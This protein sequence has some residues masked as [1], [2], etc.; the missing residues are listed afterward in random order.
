L[1]DAS[2]PNP[3]LIVQLETQLD[4]R[5]VRTA[6]TVAGWILVVVILVMTWGPI[7]DRPQLGF[8]QIERFAAYFVLASIFAVAYPR[9]PRRVG[10]GLVVGAIVLEIGQGFFPHRDPR[11]VDALAKVAGALMGVL[12][13]N[14]IRRLGLGRTTED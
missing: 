13:M 10:I 14:L 7:N 12:A 5:P 8:P 2:L 9:F 1:W 3:T 11:L 4:A 6:A